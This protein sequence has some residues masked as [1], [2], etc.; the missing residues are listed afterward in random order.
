MS[1]AGVAVPGRRTRRRERRRLNRLRQWLLRSHGRDAAPLTL[2]RRRLYILPSRQG[3]VFALMVFTMLLGAMNYDNAM[4]YLLAFLLGGVGLAAMHHAHRNLLGVELTPLGAE[5][6]HVGQ[7]VLYRFRLR[8]PG[9]VTRYDVVLRLGE[10]HSRPA[11]LTADA[12]VVVA[13]GVPARRRGRQRFDTVIV[14]SRHPGNLFR[15][16]SWAHL[17]VTATLWPAPATQPAELPPAAEQSGHEGGL[18]G[19]GEEDFAGLREFHRGDAPRRIAWKAYARDQ[20]LRVKQFSGNQEA[21]PV[22]DLDSLS[23]GD[24]EQRLSVLTRQ[25]LDCARAGRPF[26]LRLPGVGLAP[27]GGRAQLEQALTLMADFRSGDDHEPR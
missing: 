22:L 6:V 17:T 14:E 21:P 16:W 5:P 18:A 20:S 25:A 4:G 11:D 15:V 23:A 3:L 7:T 13:V 9:R 12:E 8:N 19:A 10:H 2:K 27:A 26:G 24:L 1:H